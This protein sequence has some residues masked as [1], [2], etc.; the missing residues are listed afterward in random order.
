MY[1]DLARSQRRPAL[2]WLVLHALIPSVLFTAVLNLAALASRPRPV[3]LPPLTSEYAGYAMIPGAPAQALF[4]DSRG[5][6]LLVLVPR[7]GRPFALHGG[8][9]PGYAVLEGAVGPNG[10]IDRDS[11]SVR[12]LS[13]PRLE[14]PARRVLLT[15]FRVAPV[16]WRRLPARVRVLL[17]FNGKE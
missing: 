12:F 5:T 9:V 11:V 3:P 16:G 2:E 10:R 17:E 15:A 8:V 1:D 13:D 14:A 7:T 4:I 6:P